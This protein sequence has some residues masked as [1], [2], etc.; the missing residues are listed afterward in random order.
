MPSSRILVG[1][2]SSHVFMRRKRGKKNVKAA[3]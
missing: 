2:F 1:F 3:S